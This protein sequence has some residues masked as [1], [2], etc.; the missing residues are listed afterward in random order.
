MHISLL[1]F[2]SRPDSYCPKSLCCNRQVLA[3]FIFLLFLTV[4]N[5][6][7]CDA[8]TFQYYFRASCDVPGGI[9]TIDVGVAHNE[10]PLPPGTRSISSLV[11]QLPAEP[12]EGFCNFGRKQNITLKA[13]LDAD[14]PRNDTI[15][16][17]TGTRPFP[18][19]MFIAEQTKARLTRESSTYSISVELCG[20]DGN[21]QRISRTDPSFNCRPRATSIESII[22]NN[23]QLSALDAAL[24]TT[25]PES[26]RER[27]PM[28]RYSSNAFRWRGAAFQRCGSPSK[29]RLLQYNIF[30]YTVKCIK[31]QYEAALRLSRVKSND[32]L[33]PPHSVDRVRGEA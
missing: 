29:K 21:C 24:F 20:N 14:H 6:T 22:C 5:P 13:T 32:S 18:I 27:R 15:N 4:L 8:D 7:K 3:R 28:G 2:Q 11:A 1:R 16:I 19:S 17:Y 9:A 25:L 31:D 12:S 30:S 26:G 23:D 33:H 10:E